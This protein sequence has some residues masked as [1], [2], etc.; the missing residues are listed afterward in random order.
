MRA[1]R[2][3]S[4]VSSLLLWLVAAAASAHGLLV[5]VRGDGSTVSGTL[6]YSSGAPAAGEWVEMFD[7][8]VPATPSQGVNAGQDGSFRFEG[9]EGRRYRIVGSGE[10]GHSVTSELTL[11]ANSRGQFVEDDAVAEEPGWSTPPAWMVIGGLLL[12]SI[13]PAAWLRRRKDRS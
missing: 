2:T 8:S 11:T 3:I 6:Y 1:P 12:L 9:V 13:V 5:S 10:E 7:L 4:A